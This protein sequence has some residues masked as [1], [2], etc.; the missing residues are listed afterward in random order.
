MALPVICP[1]DTCSMT[2]H[3]PSLVT[4]RQVCLRAPTSCDGPWLDGT[5]GELPSLIPLLSIVQTIRISSLA[6]GNEAS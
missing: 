5:P 4:G 2:G 1:R 6:S 3:S